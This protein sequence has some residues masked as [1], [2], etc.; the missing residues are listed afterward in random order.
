MR[1]KTLYA[2]AILLALSLSACGQKA[3]ASGENGA[4]AEAEAPADVEADEAEDL[5]LEEIKA[6]GSWDGNVY[7]NEAASMVLSL[8]DTWMASSEEDIAAFVESLGGEGTDYLAMAQDFDTGSVLQIAIEDLSVTSPIFTSSMDEDSY[9]EALRQQLDLQME[10][11]MEM[12]SVDEENGD[13]M[14]GSENYRYFNA[15]AT[16][17]GVDVNQ[18]YAVKKVGDKN[19]IAIIYITADDASADELS[20]LFS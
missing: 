6:A 12:T 19:M 13:L 1:K 8:P 9:L 17:S 14:L 7:T 10:E 3:E 18:L 11:G 2:G 4:G 20:A 5:S 15:V 16:A